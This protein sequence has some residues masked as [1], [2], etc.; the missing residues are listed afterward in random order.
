DCRPRPAKTACAGVVRSHPTVS[1][2]STRPSART[3][4]NLLTVGARRLA[5]PGFWTTP[6]NNRAAGRD[7]QPTSSTSRSIL[8]GD[9][10]DGAHEKRSDLFSAFQFAVGL[11]DWAECGKTRNVE[12]MRNSSQCGP[13]VG[14]RSYGDQFEQ[15]ALARRN[16]I[17]RR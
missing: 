16:P 15:V 8:H 10:R 1:S 9:A 12:P 6:Q 2:P 13:K 14:I 11:A 7:A 3:V 4:G 5:R 17:A